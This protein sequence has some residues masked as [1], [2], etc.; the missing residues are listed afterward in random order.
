MKFNQKVFIFRLRKLLE[1]NNI[2]Q[3]ELSL[4]IGVR[5][6]TV[7]RYFSGQRIPR[8]DVIVS[9]ANYFK[10]S[11]DYLLGISDIKNP[12]D[13]NLENKYEEDI[14]LWLSKTD[15]Y[16]ELSQEDREIISSIAK[17]LLEKH[18]RNENL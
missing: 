2:T 8:T 1:Q 16:K 9:I 6:V 18:R 15:G 3:K 7:S 11:T 12:S 14:E 17:K 4:R 13:E 5:D 10:V